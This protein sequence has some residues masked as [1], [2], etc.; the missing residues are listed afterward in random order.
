MH[1]FYLQN[2]TTFKLHQSFPTTE[3][4]LRLKSHQIIMNDEEYMQWMSMYKHFMNQAEFVID[5]DMIRPMY[6]QY[7]V[8]FE[9]FFFTYLQLLKFTSRTFKS[10]QVILKWVIYIY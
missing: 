8:N 9:V 4:N 1:W 3:P 7:C 2:T 10:Q 6:K 5:E